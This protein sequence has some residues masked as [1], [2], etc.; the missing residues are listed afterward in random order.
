MPQRLSNALAD[1]QAR[2]TPEDSDAENVLAFLEETTEKYVCV[3]ML[4]YEALGYSQYERIT[5]TDCN[6][7]AEILHTIPDWEPAGVQRFSKYGRQRAWKRKNE[8]ESS[9]GFIDVPKQMET[10]F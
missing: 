10:P 1:Y 8:D 6:R 9:D 2:F 3:S 4:A 5:K 7:I